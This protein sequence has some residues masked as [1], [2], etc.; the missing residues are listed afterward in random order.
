MLLGQCEVKVMS[1][2][3]WVKDLLLFAEGAGR[4]VALGMEM[5]RHTLAQRLA[6]LS[7]SVGC[8]QSVQSSQAQPDVHRTTAASTSSQMQ[9]TRSGQ[10]A[11]CADQA[12]QTHPLGNAPSSTLDNVHP[13]PPEKIQPH[14]LSKIDPHPPSKIDPHPPSKIDPHPPS[15]IYPHPP[16]K[17]E[18][19]PPSKID[20][21]LPDVLHPHPLDKVHPHP[22]D[23]V[24]P[25]PV[26]KL[27]P[28]PVGKPSFKPREVSV[29]SS[30]MARVL[31]FG[32]LGARIAAGTLWD[33]MKK[34]FQAS[35]EEKGKQDG[36]AGTA[37]PIGIS[38][39][40]VERLTAGL[41]RMRGAALK[42][43]QMISIQD[44]SLVPPQFEQILQRVRDGADVMP[45]KQLERTLA[46]ELG[47]NWESKV[48]SFDWLPIAAASIGQVHRA[49]S[50]QG[51]EVVLKVQYPGVADSIESDIDNLRRILQLT[52]MFPRGLFIS[53]VI[54]SAK[55]ELT[56]ECD[57]YY[58]AKCQRRFQ[59]L[60]Q[61]DES[62]RHRINVPDIIP[63]LSTR[64]VLCTALV[65][66]LPIDRLY[67]LHAD[68][69]ARNSV[70]VLMLELCL[71]ELFLWRFM[72]TDP[73]WSNF[74][75]NPNA[76]APNGGVEG[77]GGVLNLIDFGA[78][79]QYSEEFVDEY[80]KMVK[81][82]AEKKKDELMEASINLGFLTGDESKR[83]TKAHVDASFIIG[84][85]FGCQGAYDFVKGDIAAR[86]SKQAAIMMQDAL[87]PPRKEVYTLHRK[88]S[89]AFL[90]CK[91]LHATVECGPL[92]YEI[93]DKRKAQKEASE[94]AKKS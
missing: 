45:R 63:E 56:L 86:A 40:N 42:V 61:D 76:K 1:R 3:R 79:R 19:H 60:V 81:A 15:K 82:C 67:G 89:G 58:E 77:K 34:P 20:P 27:H 5:Q 25:H 57:Y 24:H 75:Y 8:A 18:P 6:P 87:R 53:E 54:E 91:K 83:M 62:L 11:A 49:V 70:A 84:E 48:K 43:G 33:R 13:H 44:E 78:T 74:L 16:S 50:L 29:P 14:P 52:D 36:K 22:L 71:K 39:G 4:V 93:L 88:L 7:R 37:A 73:N 80:L 30:P 9:A 90:M 17:I 92:F 65:Q 64:R 26:D 10:A 55:E 31:G 23:N 47:A 28:H 69:A 2:E 41:C 59:T 94:K 72:Q 85:P 66:G 68:S 38:E 32:S 51:R 12:A 21:H 46:A 35:P